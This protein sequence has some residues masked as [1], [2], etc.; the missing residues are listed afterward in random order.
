MSGSGRQNLEQLPPIVKQSVGAIALAEAIGGASHLAVG[1]VL[2]KALSGHC[3]TD[4]SFD[5]GPGWSRT[6]DVS[7][8]TDL[9]SAAFA[10]WAY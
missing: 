5:G 2:Q 10:N 4:T 1:L 3:H 7:N 9:Q 6:N 8:V